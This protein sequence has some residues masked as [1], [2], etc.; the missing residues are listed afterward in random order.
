MIVDYFSALYFALNCAQKHGL[1]IKTSNA[2]NI[3]HISFVICFYLWIKEELGSESFKLPC[4]P[5]RPSR[6]PAGRL[7]A[8]HHDASFLSERWVSLHPYESVMACRRPDARRPAA[9]CDFLA[10]LTFCGLF[11]CSFLAEIAPNPVQNVQSSKPFF[12]ALL[13]PKWSIWVEHA[14]VWPVN[15]L[16]PN[17]PLWSS[18]SHYQL[19]PSPFRKFSKSS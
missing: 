4:K 3:T 16:H 6:R 19:G 15:A 11:V 10:R 12:S 5:A 8:K 1:Q 17:A 13:G 7:F 14:P 9:M 2:S 18:N